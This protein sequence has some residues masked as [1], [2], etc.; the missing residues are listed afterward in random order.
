[1]NTKILTLVFILC[2]MS[3]IFAQN[4][5]K[6]ALIPAVKLNPVH[7]AANFGSADEYK[8]LESKSRFRVRL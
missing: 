1:M 8:V 4:Q 7:R 5:S 2:S 3:G 6:K